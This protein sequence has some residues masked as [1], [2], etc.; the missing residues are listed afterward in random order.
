MEKKISQSGFVRI[1][2]NYLVNANHV[3]RIGVKTILLSKGIELDIGKTEGSR[4][5]KYWIL[6]IRE[7]G[8]VK[9]T[10]VLLME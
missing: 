1:H 6:T 8:W 4:L 9:I 10:A 3:K 5:Y 7:G 2:K